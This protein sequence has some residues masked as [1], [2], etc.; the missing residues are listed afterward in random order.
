MSVLLYE[1]ALIANMPTDAQS[2]MD[3]A[4][5]MSCVPAGQQMSILIYLAD[6]MANKVSDTSCLLCG[7]GA[8]PVAAPACTCAIF[9]RTDT[10]SLF[11]WSA[12]TS[13]WD[14]LL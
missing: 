3:A 12:G 11:I 7:S 13:T 4:R 2:L 8:D 1:F 5:C 14:K 9:Y 6:K 10:S